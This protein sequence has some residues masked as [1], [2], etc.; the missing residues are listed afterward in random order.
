MYWVSYRYVYAIRDQSRLAD[1]RDRADRKIIALCDL[2]RL[3]R[4]NGCAVRAH[5]SARL[6]R[7][8]RSR[9]RNSAGTGLPT[10]MEERYADFAAV[11]SGVVRRYGARAHYRR[12]AI[13]N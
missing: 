9:E 13:T 2:S 5:R 6:V 12:A 8:V 1:T 11:R 3:H 10:F 7:H 4:A